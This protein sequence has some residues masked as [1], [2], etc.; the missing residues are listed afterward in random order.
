[1]RSPF[2]PCAPSQVVNVKMHVRQKASNALAG[3]V[4]SC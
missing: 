1:M 2:L 3:G 4:L